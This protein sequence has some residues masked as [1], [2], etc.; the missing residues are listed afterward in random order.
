MMSEPE[1]AD[2]AADIAENGLIHPIMLGTWEDDEGSKVEGVIDGRNRLRACE[3]AE[4]APKFA[5]LNGADPLAY[6]VSSN[7]ERRSLTVGQKAIATA[8]IYP[9]GGKGGRGNSL[10]ASPMR[11]RQ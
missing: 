11:S 8:L 4:V 7:V 6:I 10:K 1:L 2:L 3:I 5:K 9:K